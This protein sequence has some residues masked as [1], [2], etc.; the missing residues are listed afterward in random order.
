M[1]KALGFVLVFLFMTS[2]ATS[3]NYAMLLDSWKGSAVG[4]LVAQMG[5][6]RKI[7]DNDQGNKVYEYQR[8]NPD[9]SILRC[10]TKFEVDQNGT[11][12]G[13]DFKGGNCVAFSQDG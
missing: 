6:P 13:S 9:H 12:I 10:V 7:Y 11:V 3:E 1:K 8:I 5:E 2:C 4:D